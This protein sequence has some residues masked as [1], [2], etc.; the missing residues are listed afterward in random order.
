MENEIPNAA[1]RRY[2]DSTRLIDSLGD[3]ELGMR[4][5][6]PVINLMKDAVDRY[7]GIVAKTQGDGV[8]ALFGGRDLT[9][10]TPYEVA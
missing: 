7:D 1:V 10:T 5:L 4:R 6:Q 9:R 8:M 3:P 2:P